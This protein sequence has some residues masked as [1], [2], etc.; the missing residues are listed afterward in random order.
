MLKQVQ[1]RDIQESNMTF[2][3]DS[4]RSIAETLNQQSEDFHRDSLLGVREREGERGVRVWSGIDLPVPFE[5]VLE[6][7]RLRVISE[8]VLESLIVFQLGHIEAREF[9]GG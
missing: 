2:L 3:S 6:R 5:V 4:A 1:F 9:E 8:G 7:E